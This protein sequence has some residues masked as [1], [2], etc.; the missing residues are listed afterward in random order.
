MLPYQIGLLASDRIMAFLT[1]F[2]LLGSW[3]LA[4]YVANAVADRVG[5]R[6]GDFA[7][8]LMTIGY[9][10]IPML[11]CSIVSFFLTGLARFVPLFKSLD[12]IVLIAFVIWLFYLW[13]VMI[14]EICGLEMMHAGITAAITIIVVGFVYYTLFELL[15]RSILAN[16]FAR[17]V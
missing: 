16:I 14:S 10:S 9:L 8:L 13:T 5:A 6:K 7:T 17:R 15:L 1:P 3:I 11:A 4:A 12:T 2:F